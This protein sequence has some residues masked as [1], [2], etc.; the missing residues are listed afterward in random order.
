MPSAPAGNELRAEPEC[1]RSSPR[2]WVPSILETGARA[3]IAVP[4]D[5]EGSLERVERRKCP[6][7]VLLLVRAPRRTVTKDQA[8]DSRRV[9]TGTLQDGSPSAAPNIVRRFET[10]YQCQHVRVLHELGE[11]Y[12]RIARQRVS[13]RDRARGAIQ[14]NT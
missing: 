1:V 9:A 5:G 11:C 8:L 2:V 3:W 7:Y 4:L 13:R 6:R 14:L 12:A 10:R